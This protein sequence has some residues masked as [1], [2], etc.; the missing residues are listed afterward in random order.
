MIREAIIL[1]GGM[2]TRLRSAVPELPKCLAPVA[3]KPFLSYVINHLRLNGIGRI[4]FSL[5]YKAAT[6]ISFLEAAYPTLD[7]EVVVEDEPLGTG[8]AI[9]A[10]LQKIKG[11]AAVITNGDT[12][13]QV[14][15][16]QLFE[17]HTRNQALCTL[18]LKPMQQ[19][20]RYG[21]VQVEENGAVTG[22]AE[23]QFYAAGL[24]NGGLYVVDKSGFEALQ[25]PDK[26]SFEK[27]FLEPQAASGK[28]FA[29]S[30][31]VYFI[32][33][34]IPEDFARASQ[35]LQHPPFELNK[36]D[37]TWTLFLDRDGVINEEID[38]TYVLHKN[39]F[40]FM[41]GVPQA[42]A[43]LS[44][45]FGR[46]VIISN[47][48]GVGRGLMTASDLEG[49]HD[50]LL[51]GVTAAGGRIDDILVCTEVAATHA[52]RKPNPGM[53]ALAFARFPHII[54]AKTVMVGNKL[55]DMQF[56][57][58]AGV[59]TVYVKTTHPQQPLPHPLI[60][61]AFNNLPQFATALQSQH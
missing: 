53:A 2:G 35:E 18:A 25:P 39:G 58:W 19:F 38:G 17:V 1:A 13:F 51:E 55:S 29:E 27:D 42:I 37:A 15:V 47:Q 46:I 32:D 4:V 54:P 48:R 22:F 3:G 23:K 57:R 36:I 24:I 49:I 14:P 44:K 8:G 9:K 61:A 16:Q 7:Y 59:Y 45:I 21:V 56:G 50:T 43:Q 34:G 40:R 26:F 11:D 52:H 10:S 5:G 41:P 12:L 20:D 6:V 60:D 33:I 30:F 31:D 28:L